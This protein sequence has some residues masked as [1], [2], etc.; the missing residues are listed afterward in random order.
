[1]FV[2]FISN[3]SVKAEEQLEVASDGSFFQSVS[4]PHKTSQIFINPCAIFFGNL[5]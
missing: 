5:Q 1:M 4:A 3:I 2:H